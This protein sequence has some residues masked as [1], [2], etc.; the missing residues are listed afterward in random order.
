[1]AFFWCS[2]LKEIKV[3]ENVTQIATRAFDFCISLTTVKLL[4]HMEQI[5]E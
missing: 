5:G 2:S 3:P 4:S 1:M